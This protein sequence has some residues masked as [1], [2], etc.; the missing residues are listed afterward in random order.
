MAVPQVV[1]EFSPVKQVETWG[2]V[3][4]QPPACKRTRTFPS[5]CP[6]PSSSETLIF[7][8]LLLGKNE[9]V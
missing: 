4:S 9:N 2:D 6:Q 7:M 3:Y 5:A 8:V 1:N